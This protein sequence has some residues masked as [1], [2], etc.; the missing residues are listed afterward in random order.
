MTE[1]PSLAARQIS[2]EADLAVRG[3]TIAVQ[4]FWGQGWCDASTRSLIAGKSH[5]SVSA[6]DTP[7][8]IYIWP[9]QGPD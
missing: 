4:T 7:V 6:S 3:P 1:G 8:G 9:G 5:R 2:Q